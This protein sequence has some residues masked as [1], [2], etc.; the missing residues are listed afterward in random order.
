MHLNR[1]RTSW[2]ALTVIRAAVLLTVA[3]FLLG[4]HVSRQAQYVN[5]SESTVT[6]WIDGVQVT[7]IPPGETATVTDR[8][9][10]GDVDHVE[11]F[12]EDGTKL[13]D[14]TFTW[15]EWEEIDFKIVIRD[16]ETSGEAPSPAHSE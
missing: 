2:L 6:L 5:A 13:V 16:P 12:A 7:T 3:L 4:C 10:E 11:I 9:Q 14:R 8:K 1:L 15:E